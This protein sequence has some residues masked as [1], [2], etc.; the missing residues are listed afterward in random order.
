MPNKTTGE[1][2][3]N[4]TQDL[5]KHRANIENLADTAEVVNELITMAKSTQGI[6]RVLALYFERGSDEIDRA[7]VGSLEESILLIQDIQE[8]SYRH[9]EAVLALEVANV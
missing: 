9:F 2:R 6:L 4:N 3:P 5:F 8:L 7:V 1:I